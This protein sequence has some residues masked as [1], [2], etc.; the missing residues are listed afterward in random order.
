MIINSPS[1]RRKPEV[2][3]ALRLGKVSSCSYMYLD[4]ESTSATRILFLSAVPSPNRFSFR[5]CD[6][7][8]LKS[9]VFHDIRL[10]LGIYPSVP[11]LNLEYSHTN[12]LHHV[13]MRQAGDMASMSLRADV[14][15]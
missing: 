3:C 7:E 8:L 11:A 5:G 12:H 2:L 13:S 14:P 6:F 1:R 10:S 9:L 15:L 4:N